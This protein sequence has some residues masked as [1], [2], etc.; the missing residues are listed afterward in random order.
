MGE[1]FV[2]YE[3]AV[4]YLESEKLSE[5]RLKLCLNFAKR[6]E[7]HPKYQHWFTEEMENTRPVPNTRSDKNA[8]KTKYRVVPNRTERFKNSPI[9]YLTDVL[10]DHY[11][12]Q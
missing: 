3:H 5:R 7:E 4:D 12:K 10:N 2:K 11:R 8:C 6:A 9:P 1:D